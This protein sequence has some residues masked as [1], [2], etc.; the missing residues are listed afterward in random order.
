MKRAIH[1][2]TLLG[3][4]LYTITLITSCREE[5]DMV[6]SYA[7][8]SRDTSNFDE[9]NNSFEG[10]FKAIWTAM[11]CNYPIWDYEEQF[12]MDWD[13]VYDEYLPK[14]RALDERARVQHDS[15]TNEELKA[16]YTEILRPLH[17]GHFDATI[18]NLHNNSVVSLHLV[19][20]R[21]RTR[22]TFDAYVT[23][24]DY[25]IGSDEVAW[26]MPEHRGKETFPYAS[27]GVYEYACFKD[28]IVLLRLPKIEISKLLVD[29]IYEKNKWNSQVREN[30]EIWYCWF[31][32]IQELHNSGELKGIIID[33]RSNT[34]GLGNDYQYVLGA[35]QAPDAISKNLGAN[36]HQIGYIRTKSGIGRLDYLPVEPFYHPI[37]KEEHAIVEKEPIII[38]T[39]CLTCSTAEH[40]C[41]GAKQMRN[42]YIIGTRT[43][44]AFSPLQGKLDTEGKYYS[45]SYS[46]IVGNEENAPFYLHIPFAA[47]FTLD[48]EILESTGVTPDI[49]IELDNELYKNTGRDNQLERALEFIRTGK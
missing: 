40:I 14:F 45:H 42:G 20:E 5:S 7:Y 33:L 8:D 24:L 37:Y 11:N 47:F 12:G 35:I 4:V 29:S 39:N 44:G 21:Y 46:G 9:A 25:Y 10:Q 38:L 26:M 22:K 49:E 41:L 1:L 28:N 30:R 19:D 23:N 31:N 36:V 6:L 3:I 16:L 27:D 13:K 2:I 48:S 43:F 32:K 34:G 15:V 17:D 18:K